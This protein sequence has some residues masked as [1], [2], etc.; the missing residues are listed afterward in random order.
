M[1]NDGPQWKYYLFFNIKAVVLAGTVVMVLYNCAEAP[2][3]RQQEDPLSFTSAGQTCQINPMFDRYWPVLVTLA[4]A[5]L[6]WT[7]GAAVYYAVTGWYPR[8]AGQVYLLQLPVST[9]SVVAAGVG[10]AGG[11]WLVLALSWVVVSLLS[12]FAV[13]LGLL[14]GVPGLFDGG[15]EAVDDTG[16]AGAEGGAVVGAAALS[17]PHLVDDTVPSEA[18]ASGSPQQA[19]V[20]VAPGL[21]NAG[22]A[23]GGLVEGL[24]RLSSTIS[25]GQHSSRGF[26]PVRRSSKSPARRRSSVQENGVWNPYMVTVQQYGRWYTAMLILFEFNKIG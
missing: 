14:A 3:N 4:A 5:Q 22:G 16:S 10:L 11:G 24:M 17:Q 15:G 7:L 6:L 21:G 25:T 1:L 19:S 13:V 8:N 2:A 20:V 18:E 12:G 9:T 26:S 23:G